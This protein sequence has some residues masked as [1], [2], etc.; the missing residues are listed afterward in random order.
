MVYEDKESQIDT[1]DRKFERPNS[2][3][4]EHDEENV[5]KMQIAEPK[6]IKKR[7]KIKR[8]KTKPKKLETRERERK[9]P[10]RKQQKI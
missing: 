8:D 4:K 2:T 9:Q 1:R 10:Q 6:R 5:R 3:E 7:Q